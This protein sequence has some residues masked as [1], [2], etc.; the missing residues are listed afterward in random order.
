M[1]PAKRKTTTA[2]AK[3]AD[4]DLFKLHDK[5]CKA[6][7]DMLSLQAGAAVDHETATKAERALERNW[8]R[9]VDVAFQKARA[10]A[11][12]PAFTLEGMLMKIHVTGFTM[13][14][15]EKDSFS[16]PYHGQ[17]C[18]NGKPQ[19]WELREDFDHSEEAVLIVSLRSD[20]HRLMGRR[21]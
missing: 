18:S 20:L 13:D 7:S 9:S 12:A 16:A 3:T 1:A 11:E 17:I 14:Y 19:Q 6:Y 8:N 2:Y 10:V 15:R 21:V 4:A 5:F